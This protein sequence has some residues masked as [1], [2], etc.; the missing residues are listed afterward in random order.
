[1]DCHSNR[2]PYVIQDSFL[3]ELKL[4]NRV[5]LSQRGR[6]QLTLKNQRVMM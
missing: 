3:T 6:I 1:M 2:Y 4:L 5:S